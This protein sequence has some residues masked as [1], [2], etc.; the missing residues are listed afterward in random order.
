[1]PD[2]D[3]LALDI[4]D[5][6]LR[7]DFTISRAN[8]KAL[9]RCREAGVIVTLAT[10]RMLQSVLPF[11]RELE[12]MG[13]VV[14]YN[15]AMVAE[16]PSG[17]VLE[18]TPVPLGRARLLIDELRAC[19]LHVNV[20]I[21][22]RL[23]IEKQTPEAID[24]CRVSGVTARVAPFSEVLQ[25]EPTKV[26]AIAPPE[27]LDELQPSLAQTFGDL[28]VTRSKPHYLE[29]MLAGVTKGLGLQAAARHH[30]IPRSRVA[31]VGDAPNDIEMIAW[32]GLGVAVGNASQKVQGAARVVAP[33]NDEDGV[34]WVVDHFVLR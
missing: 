7:S 31:A 2:Y 12:I 8:R 5:T 21:N 30:G 18:H 32:A 10:G 1:M 6:L 23:F 28:H 26:V 16:A 24:Y 33:G 11:A 4:D 25:A 13:A 15:G 17:Q 22:D 27:R 19:R 14:A 34:A 29:F 20:Y 9:Q 3:L